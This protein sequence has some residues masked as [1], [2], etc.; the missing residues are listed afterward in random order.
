MYMIRKRPIKIPKY[1]RFRNYNER[2]LKASD[3]VFSCDE[4]EKEE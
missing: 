2:D 1:E 4:L 3:M